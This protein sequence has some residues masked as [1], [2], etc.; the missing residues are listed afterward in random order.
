MRPGI[1]SLMQDASHGAVDVIYRQNAEP[2]GHL[3]TF[4]GDL[5]P[6]DYQWQPRP[7]NRHP[8]QRALYRQAC[9]E[10]AALHQRPDHR[11]A[12]VAAKQR[13]GVDHQGGARAAHH[14]R[15]AVGGGQA[16]PG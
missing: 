11:K 9:L 2:R 14:T 3:W 5:G 4:R 16:A 12:P 6:F 10:P 1:Q 13:E 8:Q 7:R 15:G